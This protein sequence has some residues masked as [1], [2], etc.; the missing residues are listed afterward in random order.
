MTCSMEK[1]LALSTT[2]LLL[3]CTLGCNQQVTHAAGSSALP[4]IRIPVGP[5]PGPKWRSIFPLIPTFMTRW[6]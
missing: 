4:D 1:N 3:I 6:P 5:I 2:F